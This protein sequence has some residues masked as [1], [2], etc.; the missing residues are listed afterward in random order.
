MHGTVAR[1]GPAI[2]RSG[3]PVARGGQAV[4]Q[5]SQPFTCRLP[6]LRVLSAVLVQAE[7]P[8]HARVHIAPDGRSIT[9]TGPSITL[10]SRAITLV[11]VLIVIVDRRHLQRE[12]YAAN[13]HLAPTPR[14]R[15]GGRQ[16]QRSPAGPG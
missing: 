6:V 9:L 8:P 2:V 12:S 13:C 10:V 11:S 14:N 1:S 15:P 5:R 7:L 4:K 3:L 16:A